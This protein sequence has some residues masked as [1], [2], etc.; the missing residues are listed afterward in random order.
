MAKHVFQLA[1]CK[2]TSVIAA[3]KSNKT[4]KIKLPNTNFQEFWK[5][6]CFIKL[7]EY[8]YRKNK[9]V[10]IKYENNNC[11]KKTIKNKQYYTVIV[12]IPGS[13]NSNSKKN[14]TLKLNGFP[15]KT[16]SNSSYTYRIDNW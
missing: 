10:L 4:T 3:A 9:K 6:K 15:G 8:T 16:N 11:V 7:Q 1:C 2:H 5:F 13:K 12:K 14:N